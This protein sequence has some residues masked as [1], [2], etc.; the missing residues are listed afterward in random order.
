MIILNYLPGKLQISISVFGCWEII[1]PFGGTMRPWVFMFLEVLYCCT[2]IWRHTHLPHSILPSFESK[3]PSI[4]PV[5]ICRLFRDLSYGYPR[6]TVLSPSCG[7]IIRLVF[8]LSILQSQARYWQHLFFFPQGII[9][10]SSLCNFSQSNIFWQLSTHADYSFVKPC[11]YCHWIHAQESNH[12]VGDVWE[13]GIQSFECV[14]GPAGR[15]FRHCMSSKRLV[16]RLPPDGVCKL[17]SKTCV[18]LMTLESPICCSATCFLLSIYTAHLSIL[19]GVRNKWLSSSIPYNWGIWELIHMLSFPPT[20]KSW[21]KYVSL[22]LSCATLEE[23]D[24][25]KVKLP[26]NL[27]SGLIL[28]SF[29]FVFLLLQWCF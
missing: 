12:G 14:H 29:S 26:L 4:G 11:T 3:I 1:G 22:A 6:S 9:K 28:L 17:V 5:E 27:L 2:H 18:T 23:G 25:S 10:Y 19:N 16:V 20:G 21:A 24:V 13:W 8:F 7:W 15:I